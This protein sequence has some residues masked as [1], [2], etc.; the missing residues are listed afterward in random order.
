MRSTTPAGATCIAVIARPA[1]S[2][3]NEFESVDLERM[4]VLRARL[5]PPP[6]RRQE[7]FSARRPAY[8]GRRLARSARRGLPRLHGPARLQPLRACGVSSF[9]SPT[10]RHDHWRWTIRSSATSQ[11]VA[12]ATRNTATF[13]ASVIQACPETAARQRA[14]GSTTVRWAVLSE[15]SREVCRESSPSQSSTGAS[16]VRIRRAPKYRGIPSDCGF[17]SGAIQSQRPLDRS[18]GQTAETAEPYKRYISPI[19]E[20]LPRCTVPLWLTQLRV[21]LAYAFKP[22]DGQPWGRNPPTDRVAPTV[23]ARSA[24]TTVHI[25][26]SHG[27]STTAVTITGILRRRPGPPFRRPRAG[28]PPDRW[29]GRRRWG[30]WARARRVRCRRQ[31]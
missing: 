7:D 6:Q 25:G 15:M 13:N 3:Q 8:S 1:A 26:G 29:A 28:A 12:H 20:V 31:R 23:P 22:R 16:S 5:A 19:S 24:A 9:M 11:P 18:S 10:L 30:P 27:L 14:M 17:A 21:P 4:S 2:E